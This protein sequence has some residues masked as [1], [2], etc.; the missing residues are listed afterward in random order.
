MWKGI[1]SRSVANLLLIMKT[2]RDVHALVQDSYDINHSS[3]CQAK[4][5]E[6]RSHRVFAIS[7]PNVFGRACQQFS[8]CQTVQRRSDGQNIDFGLSVAPCSG[9]IIPY[10]FKI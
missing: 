4:E 3:I 6:V 10:V 2:R 1:Y 8:L 7:G 5:K 9:G